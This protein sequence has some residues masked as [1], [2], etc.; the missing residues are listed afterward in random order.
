MKACGD[1]IDRKKLEID[2]RLYLKEIYPL[3]T[4]ANMYDLD[5]AYNE[6]SNML[7]AIDHPQEREI[8]YM[9]KTAYSE[10]HDMKRTGN[11]F[12]R[13][14]EKNPALYNEIKNICFMLLNNPTGV[15][16]F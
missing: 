8:T 9:L 7:S 13:W 15:H 3:I 1:S 5:K 4:T 12:I 6:L 16:P 11:D 10:M 2:F 14:N